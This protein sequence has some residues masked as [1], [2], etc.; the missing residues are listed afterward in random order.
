MLYYCDCVSQCG[1]AHHEV[2]YVLL[3]SYYLVEIIAE[4]IFLL[5]IHQH[6]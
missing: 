4:E 2:Y 5:H 6:M 3:F 1:I